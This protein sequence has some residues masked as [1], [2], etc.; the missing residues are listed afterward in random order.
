[1]EMDHCWMDLMI[2]EP[3][4]KK[5]NKLKHKNDREKLNPITGSMMEPAPRLIASIMFWRGSKES[6]W[7]ITQI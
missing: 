4:K 6:L 1:M 5:K 7:N 2:K 3:Q